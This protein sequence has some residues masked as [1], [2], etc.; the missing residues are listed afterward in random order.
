LFDFDSDGTKWRSRFRCT[1][2]QFVLVVTIAARGDT[3]TTATILDTVLRIV[4]TIGLMSIVP[5][6]CRGH[7]ALRHTSLTV[8][9]FWLS[10]G[11]LLWDVAWITTIL[12]DQIPRGPA[13]V[14]WYMTA[15][16]LVCPAV[17]VLGARRPAVRAWAWF[18]LIPLVLVLGLPV[19]GLG[20]AG[21]GPLEIEVPAL[22]GY[23]LVLVMGT[24][25]YIG[26]RYTIAAILLMGTLGLLVVPM[27]AAVT[28]SERLVEYERIAATILLAVTVVCVA[29]RSRRQPVGF[30]SA[31]DLDRLNLLWVDFRDTFGIV[32]AQRIRERVNVT[33]ESENWP[34]RL[35]R[36]GFVPVTSQIETAQ[37]E[38]AR[39][40]I[41][42][43]QT[44]RDRIEHTFRWLLRRFVDPEWIDRRL[45]AEGSVTK[46]RE[47]P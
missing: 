45:S 17:A 46:P 35:D 14:L 32:W 9:W 12:T 27:S 42:T 26:T 29:Y 8:A 28:C 43:D 18:I 38:S 41:A 20:N 11:L 39:D 36:N 16:I 33:A 2:G 25:N 13:D 30:S 7:K 37:I 21:L 4:G 47:K 23:L 31:D 1:T 22:A 10:A 3:I 15:V 40:E 5:V 34:V 24:G 6:V 44:T 19:A